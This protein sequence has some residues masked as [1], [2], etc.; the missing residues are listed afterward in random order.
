MLHSVGILGSGAP[1][2]N[3]ASHRNDVQKIHYVLDPSRGSVVVRLCDSG[4]TNHNYRN[5]TGEHQPVGECV[6]FPDE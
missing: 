5:R 4:P 1:P 3:Y 6:Q 2:G